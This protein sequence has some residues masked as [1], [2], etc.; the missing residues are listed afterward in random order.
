MDYLYRSLWL[1]VTHG[2]SWSPVLF[3]LGPLRPHLLGSLS[4]GRPHGPC[5]PRCLS[6]FLQIGPSFTAAFGFGQPKGPY[7]LV[8]VQPS[9]Y[10]AY[11]HP[12]LRL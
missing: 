2:A 9:A 7:S 6:P 3:K 11:L 12:G 1:W 8:A 10:S 4:F 5:V